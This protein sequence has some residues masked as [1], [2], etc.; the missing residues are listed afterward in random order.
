[1]FTPQITYNKQDQ[2]PKYSWP[3]RN[4]THHR[5]EFGSSQPKGAAWEVEAEVQLC[6]NRKLGNSSHISLQLKKKIKIVFLYKNLTEN[7]IVTLGKVIILLQSL[8][9]N[10]NSNSKKYKISEFKGT[11]VSQ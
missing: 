9:K 10:C 2:D 4:S 3:H 1:M 5:K 11:T 8:I 7:L 6:T